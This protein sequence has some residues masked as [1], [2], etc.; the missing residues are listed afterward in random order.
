[1]S[2]LGLIGYNPWLVYEL[3]SLR[4]CLTLI[5]DRNG[6]GCSLGSMSQ[7]QTHQIFYKGLFGHKVRMDI[8]RRII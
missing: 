4:I 2:F 6:T 1:M 3:I 8:D 7:V 5:S